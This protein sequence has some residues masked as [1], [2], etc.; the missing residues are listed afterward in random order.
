LLLT[1]LGPA[2]LNGV[3]IHI[4]RACK[5]D[6]SQQ[7]GKIIL[8]GTV[9]IIPTHAPFL[10]LMYFT[11]DIWAKLGC[12]PPVTDVINR[13]FTAT[14]WNFPLVSL[15][16]LS[17]HL[18][19]GIEKY[20]VVLESKNQT[21]PMRPYRASI[22]INLL[23]LG[24]TAGLGGILTFGLGPIPA[25]GVVGFPYASLIQSFITLPITAT[26]LFYH[27]KFMRETFGFPSFAFRESLPVLKDLLITGGSLMLQWSGEIFAMIIRTVFAQKLSEDAFIAQGIVD[28]VE[29]FAMS[30]GF[31]ISM[32][33][34]SLAA[35]AVSHKDFDQL[36]RINHMAMLLSISTAGT[37]CI[38]CSV[39]N[40]QVLLASIF[41]DISANPNVLI[42]FQSAMRWT[43]IGFI[44]DFMRQVSKSVLMS[45]GENYTPSIMNLLSVAA[46][47]AGG[48]ALSFIA[49]L[50]L[51]GMTLGGAAGLALAAT[52]TEIY[53]WFCL[54]RHET[55]A[56]TPAL[57]TIASAAIKTNSPSNLLSHFSSL[58]KCSKKPEQQALLAETKSDSRF[59]PA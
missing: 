24:I 3:N 34:N 4:G 46:G 57:P 30:I 17:R 42:L 40:I 25:M 56:K 52:S 19:D 38:L 26:Y 54:Y 28:Q 48:W 18:L 23:G 13:Y 50:N 51:P 49:D 14:M 21:M 5:Q 6:Q 31:G 1:T 27:R 59:L 45:M 29:G 22:I 39:P 11:G 2:S 37:L 20:R 43:A 41:F 33:L 35:Q 12:T 32:S 10:V 44:P 16:T 8:Q 36:K 55:K 53:K 15:G 58:F 47:V 9:S 7:V